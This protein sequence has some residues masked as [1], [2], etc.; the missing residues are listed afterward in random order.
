MLFR[1]HSSFLKTKYKVWCLL[2]DKN[3]SELKYGDLFPVVTSNI[4]IHELKC[5]V[6]VNVCLDLGR[7]ADQPSCMSQ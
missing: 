1:S 7:I 6:T 2:V 3:S 4:D 5:Y